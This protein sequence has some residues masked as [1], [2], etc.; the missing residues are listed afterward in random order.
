MINIDTL[1]KRITKEEHLRNLASDLN[2]IDLC[3][4]YK[5]DFKNAKELRDFVEAISDLV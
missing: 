5:S 2:N 1:D 3:F 4:E